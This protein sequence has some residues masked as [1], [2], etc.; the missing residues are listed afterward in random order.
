MTELKNLK[1]S[2]SNEEEKKLFIKQ[3]KAYYDKRDDW[4]YF[5][6][7]EDSSLEERT[8][9]AKQNWKEFLYVVWWVVLCALIVWFFIVQFSKKPEPIIKTNTVTVTGNTY[10]VTIDTKKLPAV[11]SLVY[12]YDNTITAQKWAKLNQI[13]VDADGITRFNVCL[14]AEKWDDNCTTWKDTNQD[15]D[16]QWKNCNRECTARDVPYNNCF[17][18]SII[19]E[20]EQDL[21]DWI[22]NK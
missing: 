15:C 6:Y 16:D 5:E 4:F 3:S 2:F 13:R 7:N 22:C 20:T 14:Q 19:G 12:Y 10:Q 17:D 9:N 1:V 8:A 11:G 18:I 21:K